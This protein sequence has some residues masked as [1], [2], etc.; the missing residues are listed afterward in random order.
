MAVNELRE[1]AD[2]GSSVDMIRDSIWTVNSLLNV[3]AVWP[4]SKQVTQARI[5]PVRLPSGEVR[6]L[7]KGSEFFVIDREPYRTA[8]ERHVKLLN[9]TLADVAELGPF[10]QW[11]RLEDRYLSN[12]V[13]EVTSFGGGYARVVSDNQRQICNRAHALLRFVLSIYM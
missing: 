10:L 11:T 4:G 9:F 2:E 1:A 6:C 5:F 3:S 13:K 7:S 8:F 12:C